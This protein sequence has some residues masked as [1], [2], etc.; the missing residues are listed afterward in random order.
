MVLY[1]AIV[2]ILN[3]ALGYALAVYL[4]SARSARRA[5]NSDSASDY[6][7]IGDYG[8]GGSYNER[9]YEHELESS[10]SS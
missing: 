5:A 9:T 4:R 10:V 7:E 6:D 3:V 2:A 1:V 8:S